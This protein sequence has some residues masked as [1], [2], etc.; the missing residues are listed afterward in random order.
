MKKALVTGGSG[1]LGRAIVKLLL[2]L[3]VEVNIL[4]RKN[5]Q[6]LEKMGCQVF[7]GEISDKNL[8][9]KATESC[10]TVFHTAAKAGIEEPYSEYFRINYE[11]T[12]AVIEACKANKVQR[13][14]YT[15]S[16]SVIFSDGDIEGADESIP[17][18][19]KHEAYYPKTKC[20]A[21][22]AALMANGETLQTTALRPHL[23]WGPGDNH[24]VPR[25]V[26]KAKAGKMKFVGNGKNVVD[27]TYVDNAAK[28]HILAALGLIKDGKPA[29]NAYFI[30]NGEPM[31]ISEITNKLIATAGCDPV[32][33]TIP[34]GVAK[35]LGFV[36]EKLYKTFKLKGE[37]P[38]TRWV[39][40]ELSTAHWF[41]IEKAKNDFSYVPE[42]SIEEGL[43][44]LTEYYKA[45]EK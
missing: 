30:T 28:A 7:K 24:L 1:F 32:T 29:G 15:S 10:D 25:L 41:N 18:P 14:V 45:E 26:S 21:E 35:A 39:A 9:I 31:P 43:K 6:D 36:F 23:I 19:P 42:V 33:A 34:L 3:N 8:L 12:L 11:G 22:Q 44:R 38:I 37:P 20:M 27:T 2:E 4:C 17:Y 13:L 16:P 40:G 5:Y